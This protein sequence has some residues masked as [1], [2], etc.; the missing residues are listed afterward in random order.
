MDLSLVIVM[1]A[2]AGTAQQRVTD[3]EWW[4]GMVAGTPQCSQCNAF[5][6]RCACGL[7]F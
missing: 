1:A 5:N 3:V 2:A 7:N 4:N 6:V